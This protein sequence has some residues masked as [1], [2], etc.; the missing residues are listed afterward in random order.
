[1]K[2]CNLFNAKLITSYSGKHHIFSEMTTQYKCNSLK[3]AL[4]LVK[5]LVH[6]IGD[7]KFS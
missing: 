1:M 2:S 3:L 7:C 4:K 5:E 6:D